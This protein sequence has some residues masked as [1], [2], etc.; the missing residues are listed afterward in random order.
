MKFLITDGK[1]K[2]G[3]AYKKSNGYENGYYV[4]VRMFDN[5]DAVETT[6]W[7]TFLVY[8]EVLEDL[9]DVS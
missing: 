1:G 8:Y 2:F 7:S 3:H 9:E 4:E 5:Y 6:N